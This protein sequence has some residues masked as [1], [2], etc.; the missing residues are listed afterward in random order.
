MQSFEFGT[1]GGAAGAKDAELAQ[2][3]GHHPSAFD[4]CV[5]TGMH[6]PT[7]IF[8]ANLTHF[9]PQVLLSNDGK[10]TPVALF[11]A[12]I[13]CKCRYGDRRE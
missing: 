12:A 2:T 8:L 11:N 3:L 7:C 1:A 10:G 9:S 13:P 6:G 5:P 4:S